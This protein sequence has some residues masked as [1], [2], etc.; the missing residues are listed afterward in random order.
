MYVL[1]FRELDARHGQMHYRLVLVNTIQ[2]LDQNSSW[3]LN[4]P[5]S[6]GRNPDHEVCINHDSIS[7]THCR[8]SLNGEG[9]LVVRDLNSMNGTYVDDKKITQSLLMPG[10]TLQLGSVTLRI[11]YASDTDPGEP[12]KK[13]KAYDLSGTVPMKLKTQSPKKE[14]PAPPKWWQLW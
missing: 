11:E 2:G 1:N 9:A 12:S 13:S 14:Q 4:L 10:D 3:T 5:V 6:I 8:L 7:R